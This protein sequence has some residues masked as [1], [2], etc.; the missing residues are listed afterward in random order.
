MTP[1]DETNPLLT[2]SIVTAGNDR[3]Q[4]FLSGGAKR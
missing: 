1:P 4:G 2:R 3:D